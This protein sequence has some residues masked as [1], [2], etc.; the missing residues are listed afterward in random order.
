LHPTVALADLVKDIKVA[1][2]IWVRENRVF[3]L[4]L[5]ILGPF[6]TQTSWR[7]GPAGWGF[8]DE[9]SASPAPTRDHR[10][11]R[12]VGFYPGGRKWPRSLPHLI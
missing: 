6:G 8:F 2:S 1:S 12:A 7:H 11:H 9:G 4:R 10:T 3:H 5:M